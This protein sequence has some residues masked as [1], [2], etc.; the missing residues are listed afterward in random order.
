LNVK[1][2]FPVKAAGFFFANEK[3]SE[4][5][6]KGFFGFQYEILFL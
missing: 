3:P 2:I 1:T 5:A 4:L 6:S